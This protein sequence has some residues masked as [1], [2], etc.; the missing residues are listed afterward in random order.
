MHP[1]MKV[2]TLVTVKTSD[3][4]MTRLANLTKYMKL[5][6]SQLSKHIICIGS[7]TCVFMDGIRQ[8][9]VLFRMED[10]LI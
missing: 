3:N 4:F 1:F 10:A 6:M 7:K 5:V 9:S 8:F 2:A